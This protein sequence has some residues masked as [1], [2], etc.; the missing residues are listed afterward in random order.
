MKAF[1]MEMEQ[2]LK[3]MRKNQKHAVQQREV[4]DKLYEQATNLVREFAHLKDKRHLMWAVHAL[5]M[6]KVAELAANN[7]T[8]FHFK[9]ACAKVAQGS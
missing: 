7:L 5:G 6:K 2:T 1:R 8:S 9:K 4:R 3:R